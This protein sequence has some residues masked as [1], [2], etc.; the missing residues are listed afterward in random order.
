MTLFDQANS[1]LG[2]N[3]NDP[4]AED[5][6][7]G[8]SQDVVMKGRGSGIGVMLAICCSFTWVLAICQELR[9]CL[10]GIEASLMGD[11]EIG[12][13]T[14]FRDMKLVSLSRPRFVMFIASNIYRIVFAAYLGIKGLEWVTGTADVGDLILNALAL[15]SVLEVDELIFNTLMPRKAVIFVS[16]TQPVPIKNF[17]AGSASILMFYFVFI[18]GMMGYGFHLTSQTA[19]DMSFIKDSLCNGTL[20]F[21]IATQFDAGL[22]VAKETPS[23]S[24]GIEGMLE[25]AAVQEIIEMQ[26]GVKT[27]EF[28]WTQQPGSKKMGHLLKL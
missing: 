19:R 8:N 2:L 16:E 25:V 20:N 15:T 17:A 3:G 24:A 11:I 4:L 5:Y 18:A 21:T 12:E 13:S 22:V 28:D 26:Y 10:Q 1:Y 23:A 6:F 9:D 14:K 27:P 7:T